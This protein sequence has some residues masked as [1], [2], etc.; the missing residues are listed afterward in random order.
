VDPKA[1][2]LDSMLRPSP[3]VA[4]D[5]RMLGVHLS[6]KLARV[7]THLEIQK[8]QLKDERFAFQEALLENHGV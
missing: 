8:S 7:Q 3:S 2:A 4:M 5:H 1:L 6:P